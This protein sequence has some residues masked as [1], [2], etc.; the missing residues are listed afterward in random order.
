MELVRN[1]REKIEK[2]EKEKLGLLAEID[3]LKEKAE[4]SAHKLE[5]EVAM[6]RKE[7]KTLERLLNVKEKAR[8][9][10]I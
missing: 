3:S 8:N 2:L 4:T 5:N 10:E 1:L 9:K 6:L 7:V